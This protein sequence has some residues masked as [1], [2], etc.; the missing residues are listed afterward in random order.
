MFN[1]QEHIRQLLEQ[2]GIQFDSAP[3]ENINTSNTDNTSNTNKTD[4]TNGIL[5][6][7][8]VTIAKDIS[9]RPLGTSSR[10]GESEK[11]HL[12]VAMS[13]REM[14]DRNPEVTELDKHKT[15]AVLAGQWIE[16]DQVDYVK[17]SVYPVRDSKG[18]WSSF[19]ILYNLKLAGVPLIHHKYSSKITSSHKDYISYPRALWGDVSAWRYQE[20]AEFVRQSNKAAMPAFAGRS[21][22]NI[23]VRKT[24]NKM[25]NLPFTSV[26]MY[27]DPD[28]DCWEMVIH[29]HD[30]SKT[31]IGIPDY[32]WNPA[33]DRWINQYADVKRTKDTKVPPMISFE[34]RNLI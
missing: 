33:W 25:P 12:E 4:K 2:R 26:M 27:F 15:S 9:A 30:F 8:E 31:L 16:Q 11:S 32:I 17:A 23:G 29:H 10:S 7:Q 28:D 19:K 13:Q 22:R 14:G 6:S 5:T 34:W 1:S 18:E 21:S 3:G 20:I 24:T